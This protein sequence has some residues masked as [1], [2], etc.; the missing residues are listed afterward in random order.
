[1]PVLRITKQYNQLSPLNGLITEE[2][3]EFGSKA[4]GIQ[5][6][7]ATTLAKGIDYTILDYEWA[8][9]DL[10]GAGGDARVVG[11]DLLK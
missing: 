11:H 9:V 10:I 3:I 1:M 7:A 8:L 5:F 2:R 4:D 6:L